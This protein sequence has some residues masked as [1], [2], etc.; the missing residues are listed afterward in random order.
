[1]IKR[2]YKNLKR[3][4]SQKRNNY[5][6]KKYKKTHKRKKLGKKKSKKNLGKKRHSKKNRLKRCL[7]KSR[8]KR[9]LKK[10]RSKRCLKKSR[11][12]RCLKKSRSKK[13]RT[14]RSS[15]RKKTRIRKRRMRGGALQKSETLGGAL[16]KWKALAGKPLEDIKSELST[17][18]DKDINIT[19][20]RLTP[21][22]YAVE[23]LKI[24]LVK[25]LLEDKK[26]DVNLPD[27]NGVTALIKAAQKDSVEIIKLLLEAEANVNAADK[28]GNTA[29]SVICN[30]NGYNDSKIAELLMNANADPN[31]FNSSGQTAL[32]VS[33]LRK[34]IDIIEILLKFENIDLDLQNNNSDDETNYLKTALMYAAGI[35]DTDYKTPGTKMVEILVDANANLDLKD[36]S[37]KTA[38]EYSKFADNDALKIIEEALEKKDNGGDDSVSDI[39]GAI[40]DASNPD[41]LPWWMRDVDIL[42]DL[43][44]IIEEII[45]NNEPRN[46]IPELVA[47]IQKVKL[48]PELEYDIKNYLYKR[49]EFYTS[50]NNLE[51]LE[52]N[53]KSAKYNSDNNDTMTNSDV[54]IKKVGDDK[55][56]GWNDSRLDGKS[57]SGDE[58]VESIPDAQDPD[59]DG[60]GTP[61]SAERDSDGDGVADSA[62]KDSDG[63]GVAD[64]DDPDG[65]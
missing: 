35:T 4:K 47:K 62:E 56:L 16:Q 1:M 19:Y 42:P 20:V 63:D 33:V 31:I 39:A 24:N 6:R 2:K 17:Y 59:D 36:H 61:D 41:N 28:Y 55:V 40:K 64:D 53:I 49:G 14:K 12:K 30:S 23:E 45:E 5:K 44:D 52:N 50:S 3:R 37:N 21:L 8:S 18:D 13:S 51:K 29:L 7:K 65:R 9:H 10:R 46:K 25:A 38:F 32:M 26:V 27:K 60:D 11:S 48:T 34:N 22:T 43:E 54:L 15:K 58:R 57:E